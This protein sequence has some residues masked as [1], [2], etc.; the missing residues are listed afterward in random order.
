MGRG[1]GYIAQARK[2][3]RAG[4]EA[5]SARVAAQGWILPCLHLWRVW[6]QWTH[7]CST[8]SKWRPRSSASSSWCTRWPSFAGRS[9][10]TSLGRG[11][12]VGLKPALWTAWSA[13]LIRANSSWIDWNRHRKPSQSSQK[14]FLTNS[15]TSLGRKGS[16]GMKSRWRNDWVSMM[17]SFVS[18][19][20]RACNILSLKMNKDQS[21]VCW[22]CSSCVIG[23]AF[24]HFC[25]KIIE[26]ETQMFV[27][28]LG[29]HFSQCPL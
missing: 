1:S 24:L 20:C 6:A 8:S 29:L 2:G 12:T 18:R 15:I 26:W 28:I 22:I 14:T 3:G 25:V 5:V 7:S 16:S 27:T 13:S 4:V 10:W 21:F 11:W 23:C 9:A 19:L 17:G